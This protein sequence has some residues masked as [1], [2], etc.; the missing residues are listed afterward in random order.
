MRFDERRVSF[1][2]AL[3]LTCLLAAPGVLAQQ[4]EPR[5]EFGDEVQVTEVLL[6]V[7]VTDDDGDV[8]IGL[9]PDDFQVTENGEPVAVESVRF[10]SSSLP[11]QS[12]L[13]MREKGV[14]VDPEPED[15][16]FILFFDD[17]RKYAE[18]RVN[19]VQQQLRAG[20]DAAEWVAG[21][22]AP[23]D[24]VAVVGYGRSLEVY[25]DFT[26]DPQRIQAAIEKA[27]AGRD[28]MGNWPSRQGEGG[29]SLLDDLPQ[30]KALTRESTR[31]YSALE[32]VAEAAGDILGRKNLIY[33]GIGFG[34]LDSFGQYE[35]DPRY[36]PDAIQALND[37]NV[38]M[39]TIDVT[40]QNVSHPFEAA[41]SDLAQ[42][43][44]GQYFP[45]YTSFT[46]P[47]QRIAGQTTGYYLLSYRSTHPAGE[48]GFQEVEV[49]TPNPEFKVRARQ[50][51][52]Y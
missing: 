19:L 12:V 32:L 38:A 47:L 49:D 15:R 16:Y 7:V 33:V 50:G 43:T 35:R 52:L 28:G 10:Y 25:T 46:T 29:P 34:R 51:Y 13:A 23:A 6:D 31:I 39:Y 48:S 27:A 42:E 26:R 41:L 30:G 20:R 36:Y 14:E 44:G 37:N 2:L 21:S 45:F 3:L 17:V 1:A 40:P 24:W 11:E 18:S 8:V 22:L 9:G 5:A 4:D